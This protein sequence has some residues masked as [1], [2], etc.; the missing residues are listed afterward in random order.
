[1]TNTALLDQYIKA[2]GL[3]YS[4]LAAQ[5]HITVGTFRLKRRN[6]AEFKP[7]EIQILCDLLGLTTKTQR[8]S[9]FFAHVGDVSLL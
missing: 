1:M 3:K 9:V 7:S 8:E 5:L 6:Q 2:K 4:Y